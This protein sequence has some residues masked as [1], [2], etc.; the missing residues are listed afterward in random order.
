MVSN[1]K[2]T[3]I[4]LSTLTIGKE[5]TADLYNL[6]TETIDRYLRKSGNQSTKQLAELAG[7]YT[8]DELK[9]LGSKKK[10]T[11][12]GSAI[13]NFESEQIMFLALTDTHIGSRYTNEAY[14]TSAIEEGIKQNCQFMVHAGDVTEGMSGRDGHVYE[15]SHIGY[16]EQRKASIN[17]LSQWPGKFYAISGN[18]DLWYAAKNDNGGIIVEDICQGLPNGE[19]LGEHEGS[20][21]INGIEIRLWHG[22]DTGSYATSYRLQKLVESFSG[23]EKPNVLFCGHT[24]KSGYIFERNCHIVTLGSIQK[25]SAWMRRKR[26]A[27]HCGFYVITMGIRDKEVTYFEP[28]FYPFYK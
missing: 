8:T 24:H 17:L 19:Y 20:I 21:F 1:G 16:K 23:G 13:V 3:E 12:S 25:Q 6:T 9:A 28:R 7:M 4:L 27:A 18:H 26:L 14:I 5:R 15:L 10:S 2:A 22:E 11:S